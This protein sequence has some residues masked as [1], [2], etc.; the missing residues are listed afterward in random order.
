[1]A[2]GQ[3][4][5][6]IRHL[7]RVVRPRGA[8][9]PTDAQLLERFVQGHDEA[10][11]ELL[12]WRHGAMVHNV[13]L[14]VLRR[15]H[16]A[17]DAFQATFLALVRKAGSIGNRASVGGW[18]YKVAY[19]VALRARAAAPVLP[20][21]AEPLPD[22][23]A[24]DPV[25]ELLGRE[26]GSVLHEEINRLPDKYRVAFVLCHLEGQTIETAARSLGC[27]PGTVGTRVARARDLLR[28]RLAR[29]GVGL[30]AVGA[31]L[32]AALVTS[33]VQAALLRTADEG[34]AAGLISAQAAALM[35]GALR[36]MSMTKWTLAAAVI[37]GLSLF[38]GGAAVV[39]HRAQ[40]GEPAQAVQLV[41][42]TE[43][44]AVLRWKFVK[45]TPFY[46]E[47]TTTTLQTM[48]AMNSD[49]QQAQGQTFYFSWTPVRKDGRN[50]Q[51]KQRI[52][53]VKM[54]ID[55]GGNK[56]EYDST[57]ETAA[58]NPL[59]EFFKQ[60]VGS[61]SRVTLN[62]EYKVLKVDKVRRRD[63]LLK[64]P[65]VADPALEKAL[66]TVREQVFS[67][68]AAR[69]VDEMLF[70][71]LPLGPVEAGDSWTQKRWWEL[72]PLGQC[73]ATYRYTY[74]G[75]EGGLD[76]IAIRVESALK[77]RPPAEDG[78]GLPFT[79]KKGEWKC[80]EGRGTL[81]FDRDR[82]RVTRLDL[83]LRIEGRL[84]IEIGGQESPVEMSQTQTIT[85][86]TTDTNPIPGVKPPA[87]EARE[88]DRLRAEN[89]R[90]RQRLRAVEEALT[91]PR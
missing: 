10:A 91:R 28:R 51:L 22:A 62:E 2:S 30:S 59:S 44:D 49:V 1:M 8:D 36:T 46:Q 74:L 33:T 58:A 20:L 12:V 85:V 71:G 66:G 69:L 86:R 6:L 48:K 39:A 26:L 34:V 72:G 90:L 24:A 52:E 79:F 42:E 35:K 89:A 78:V 32:P 50:W 73:R 37:L 84:T 55:I 21:P 43:P 18:L 7:R 17:E 54:D 45:N 31:A 64:K 19:R 29:R 68:D 3:L 38:G 5:P 53:G 77:G 9:G 25:Q 27:P 65:S 60:L 56:I 61:E 57:R 47:V 13:C 67:E 80:T 40:A 16:D 82:G 11:F 41:R 83:R 63:D 23:S 87:D 81:L 70:E 15:E 4:N 75:R 88:I 76:R 14:R